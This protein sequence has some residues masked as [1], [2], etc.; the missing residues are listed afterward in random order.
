MAARRVAVW[1]ELERVVWQGRGEQRPLG[2]PPLPLELSPS[3]ERRPA[4]GGPPLP[5]RLLGWPAAF[6]LPEWSALRAAE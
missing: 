5:A 1:M 4:V 6:A 3:L 2:P